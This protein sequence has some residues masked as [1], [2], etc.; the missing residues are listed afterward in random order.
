MIS[1]GSIDEKKGLSLR[2]GFEGG[3]MEITTTDIEEGEAC[4][5]SNYDDA[6][7]IDPDIS[8][9]YID[10]KIQNVLGHCQKDF[11][12][13]FTA[14]NLGAKFGGYGS[15][16]PT[17]QRSPVGPHPKTPLKLHA[18]SAPESPNPNNVHIEASQSSASQPSRKGSSANGRLK[19]EVPTSCGDKSTSKG[20]QS[21]N[22]LTKDSDQKSLKVR[23]KVGSEKLSTRKKAEIYSGLGLDVSPS[24]SL[25]ASPADSNGFFHVP[26]DD[27]NESPTSILEI[28]TSFP[29]LGSLVS[30]LPYDVLHLIEKEKGSQE[31]SVTAL[32]GSDLSKADQDVLGDL[33]DIAKEEP[34]EPVLPTDGGSGGKIWE[35]N[36]M[37]CDE[38]N[39]VFSIKTDSDVSIGSKIFDSGPMKPLKQRDDQKAMKLAPDKTSSSG[40]KRKSKGVVNGSQGGLKNESFT[41]KSKNNEDHKKNSGKV[42]DTYKDFFGELDLEHE[43]DDDDDEMGLEKP[44]GGNNGKVKLENDSLSG[45]RERLIGKKSEKPSLHATTMGNGLVSDA[46]V[47]MVAPVV[48][49]DWVCCDKCEKWRLLPPGVNPSS[50]PEKWLCSMLDWL[51]GMN[52][53]S[54]SEEETTKA[55]ISR[56][57][58]PSVQGVQPVHPGGPQLV[59]ISHDPDG[60]HQHFGSQI[61]HAGFKKKHGSK[62]LPNEVKLDRPSMSSNSSKKNLHASYRSRSLNATNPSPVNGIDFQDSGQSRDVNVVGQ[63]K[64]LDEGNNNHHSKI[65]NKRESTQDFPKDCKKVKTNVEDGTFH[66]GKFDKRDVAKKRKRENEVDGAPKYVKETSETNH[67][68]EKKAK[69]LNPKDEGIPA[70]KGKNNEDVKM[71]SLKVIDSSRKD[72]VMA[73]TS[74][75]SK[76]S[77]S[78]KTKTNNN[79]E[80]KGSPVGSVSSSPLRILNNHNNKKN[81]GVEPLKKNVYE[82]KS[83]EG[84]NKSQG[85]FT[86]GNGKTHGQSK[87]R[88]DVRMDQDSKKTSRKDVTGKGKSKSLPPRGQNEKEGFPQPLDDSR[89]E[90]MGNNVALKHHKKAQN[91]SGNQPMNVKHPSPAPN[92]HKDKGKDQDAPVLLLVRDISNQATTSAL[93]EATNLKHTADRVKNGGSS[94]E[95]RGLYMQAALKFLH[96]ASVFESCHKETGRYGDMIQSVSIYG[97]TAKLCEYCAHEYERTKE[98]GTAA[99]AYKCMEVAYMKVIYSSHATATKDVNELQSSLQTGGSPSSSAASASDVDNLNNHPAAAAAIAT[100]DKGVNTGNHVIAAQHKPNFTRILSFAQNVNS[101]MEA[102]RK[103]RIAFAG[104]TSKEEAI[105][106]KTALDF[107]FHDV[108]GLLHRVRVAMEVINR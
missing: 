62:D 31:S 54:I 21:V 48:N 14:E 90:N 19:Q 42:K 34:M 57:P 59:V 82:E 28:M 1:V 12:G 104:S 56:V 18:H 65:S 32:H 45:E 49:E 94:L 68:R 100:A 29:V 72:T 73:A 85:K 6:S 69:I 25:E 4:F 67:K 86:S 79:Q 37:T 102:S 39:P 71:R 80:A 105:K 61:P 50:L 44:S 30:P 103:S 20:Y 74:S 106:I 87:H 3:K 2:Y 84:R 24:S 36:N 97:S 83:K 43:D 81:K 10:E 77:G 98:M 23:I 89:K 93:R 40:G 9:S 60:T 53:C 107:N 78:H 92:M 17:Y 64:K 52:R 15:F 13:G 22:N 38:K 58:G 33:F 26:Q 51:P 16:L 75:S 99:L 70:R 108:E 47:P 11:E 5:Q 101:A 35:A 91:N 8:L 41:S 46:A 96:V 88:S 27:H 76:V 63:K 95:S 7:T 66:M 55:M